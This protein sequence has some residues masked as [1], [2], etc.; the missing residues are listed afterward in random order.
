M[1]AVKY[2][3]TVLIGLGLAY[4]T[5]P[6]FGQWYRDFTGDSGTWIDVTPLLGLPLAIIL[7]IIL[8]GFLF[9]KKA[10]RILTLLIALPFIF[11]QIYLDK[12]HWYLPIVLGLIAFGLAVLLRKIFKIRGR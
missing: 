12:N 10:E 3:A 4:Y 2:I 1:R 6:Y 7:F 9:Q 11:W 8:F 5:S